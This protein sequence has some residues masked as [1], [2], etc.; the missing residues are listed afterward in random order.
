MTLPSH[1]SVVGGDG[2]QEENE[3]HFQHE[4]REVGVEPRDVRRRVQ[5]VNR[6]A[7]G[8]VPDQPARQFIRGPQKWMRLTVHVVEELG[9]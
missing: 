4:V 7:A 1:Q 8:A 2:A 3:E 5:D 9:G 6:C